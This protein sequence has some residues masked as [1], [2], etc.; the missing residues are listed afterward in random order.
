MWRDPGLNLSAGMQKSPSFQRLVT[1]TRPG[2]AR[3]R[4]PRGSSRS[5]VEA[6]P[7]VPRG[8]CWCYDQKR[9]SVCSSPWNSRNSLIFSFASR[10]TCTS[11]NAAGR[12]LRSAFP[13]SWT[14]FWNSNKGACRKL[15]T[16]PKGEPL[17]QALRR[18]LELFWAI[19]SVPCHGARAKYQSERD[20]LSRLERNF[21]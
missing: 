4:R 7:C 8:R 3:R 21:T 9:S 6:A 12:R 14:G 10:H 13:R 16:S 17:M 20:R 11:G 15:A 2:H 18:G 19:F 1:A 5:R